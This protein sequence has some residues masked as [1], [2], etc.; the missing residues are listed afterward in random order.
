MEEGSKELAKWLITGNP[1]SIGGQSPSIGL[2]ARW[3]VMQDRSS[4]VAETVGAWS[5]VSALGRLLT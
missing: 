3:L 4:K 5:A 2:V 1:G